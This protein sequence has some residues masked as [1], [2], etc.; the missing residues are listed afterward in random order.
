M[1]KSEKVFTPLLDLGNEGSF[2]IHIEEYLPQLLTLYR[3][4]LLPNP[5]MIKLSTIRHNQLCFST[6]TLTADNNGETI[7]KHI[8]RL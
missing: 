1:I 8:S 2:P 4:L 5:N 6:E 3:D 7:I